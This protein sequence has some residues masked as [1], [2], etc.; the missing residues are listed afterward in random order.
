MSE[1]ASRARDLHRAKLLFTMAL[2]CAGAA[3]LVSLFMTS[4]TLA[5][6]DVVASSG[7]TVRLRIY[8]DRNHR[9]FAEAEMRSGRQIGCSQIVGFGDAEPDVT[10]ITHDKAAGVVRVRV[11][12]ANLVYD[13][14][15]QG[16]VFQ[17][18]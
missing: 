3:V 15:K 18:P 2:F 6:E 13:L 10:E 11:G 17:A 1:S 14:A 4:A 12:Q 9:V 7:E 16:F 5:Q 8:R